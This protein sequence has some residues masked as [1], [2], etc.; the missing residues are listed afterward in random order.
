M[1]HPAEC[2]EQVDDEQRILVMSPLYHDNEDKT[3]EEYYKDVRK[4]S[5][6]QSRPPS[7]ASSVFPPERANQRCHCAC[8]AA[9]SPTFSSA[10]FY[11][12]CSSSDGSQLCVSSRSCC[13]PPPT[14]LK[15]RSWW[16]RSRP[17]R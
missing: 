14:R 1:F 8:A 6:L 13:T 17:R 4:P 11:Y 12:C 9:A 2:Y 7:V 15:M 5:T 16:T 10:A 3:Q